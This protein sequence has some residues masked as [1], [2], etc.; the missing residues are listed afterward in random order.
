M[1][2]PDVCWLDDCVGG[3][4]DA[5]PMAVARVLVSTKGPELIMTLAKEAE[6]EGRHWSAALRYSIGAEATF[7]LLASADQAHQ[8]FCS[9]ASVLKRVQAGDD[10]CSQSDLEYL[11]LHIVS[12]IFSFWHMEDVAVY[13]GRLIAAIETEAAKR[14]DVERLTR[15]MLMTEMYPEWLGGNVQAWGR[16]QA[17]IMRLS[18]EAASREG[19]DPAT[20]ARILANGYTWCGQPGTPCHYC[21][22]HHTKFSY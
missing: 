20:R 21:S 9:G 11:E 10:D 18:I 12:S 19:V 16:A 22:M 15:F 17:K 1:W 8:M 13:K 6:L 2:R 4:Q 7:V 14:A 5:I 3:Q